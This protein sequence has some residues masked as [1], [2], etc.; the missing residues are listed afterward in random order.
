MAIPTRFP[1]RFKILVAVLFV[2]TAVVGII[3]FTMANLFHAD[4]KTY[5]HDLVSVVALN[6]AEESRSLL[7]GYRERLQVYARLVNDRTLSQEQKSELLKGL[8]TDFRD[9]LVVAIYES[10][11]EQAAIYDVKALTA[12]GLTKKEVQDYRKNHPPP[13]DLIQAEGV[14][15]ER[16]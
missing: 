13:F 12:A 14:S 8:S 4:K 7:S 16:S 9:F 1:I 2:I 5:I 6:T 11:K 10:G 15:I 3:T